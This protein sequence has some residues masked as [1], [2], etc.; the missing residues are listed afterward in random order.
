MKA[1]IIFI[2]FFTDSVLSNAQGK[3]VILRSRFD[4]I[5]FD[6]MTLKDTIPNAEGE[7]W[8]YGI[9]NEGRLYGI[10]EWWQRCPDNLMRP[11]LDSLQKYSTPLMIAH[12]KNGIKHGKEIFYEKDF[13]DGGRRETIYNYGKK[14]KYTKW[15][16]DSVKEKEECYDDKGNIK[17]CE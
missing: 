15:N 11:Y 16:K 14:I 5:H 12:Y 2:V 3:Q 6:F 8:I 17:N 7:W 10:W 9:E 4:T 13:K 1:F